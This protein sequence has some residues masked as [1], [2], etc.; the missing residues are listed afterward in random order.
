MSFLNVCTQ[1]LGY[2]PF[3]DRKLL[4]TAYGSCLSAICFDLWLLCVQAVMINGTVV[5]IVT[6]ISIC[7]RLEGARQVP[8]FTIHCS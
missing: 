7:V 6:L 8:F 2:A 1:F 3:P 4:P 5:R